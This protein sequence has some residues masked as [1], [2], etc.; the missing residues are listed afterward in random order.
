MRTAASR[1]GVEFIER[2]VTDPM[3][4]RLYFI[5][6]CA[7]GMFASLSCKKA[8][9]TETIRTQR[10]PYPPVNL[11]VTGTSLDAV[12][13]AWA[14]VRNDAQGYVV[15]RKDS[16]DWIELAS[17]DGITRSYHDSGL[18]CGATYFYTAYAFND[19]GRSSNADS[20]LATTK[21]ESYTL[22]TGQ[23]PN[24]LYGVAV[25]PT[26][27]LVAVG[28]GGT[29]L[30]SNDNGSSW[31]AISSNTAYN[32][33]AAAFSS[34]GDCII[35]GDHAT[36]LLL[37]QSQVSVALHSSITHQLLGL[38]VTPKGTIFIVGQQGIVLRSRDN[39][40]SWT[41]FTA[42][43]NGTLS[44]VAFTTELSGIV[45]TTDSHILGTDDGGLSWNEQL[46]PVF[47]S[48]TGVVFSDP[49]NG[50]AYG[51]NVILHTSNRGTAWV[52]TEGIASQVNG[53]CFLSNRKGIAV[54]SR[55]ILYQTADG[56]MSWTHITVQSQ[57]GLFAIHQE[58]N[59]SDCVAVGFRGIVLLASFC[60]P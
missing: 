32:L 26:G 4:M 48:L 31:N 57:P 30:Q 28:G 56:G 39:G 44:G 46:N 38:S 1:A 49:L 35:V 15:L 34:I 5:L 58:N 29:I 51:S 12:D 47:A 14:S 8:S 17:V 42:G 7:F 59:G 40:S 21:S 10:L 24:T 50:I 13:L 19:S 20:V 11:V 27:T 54:G 43:V 25:G 60:S 53:A 41:R 37:H 3:N 45:V 23:S 6:F 2:P 18:R 22:V 16:A 52:A 33:H 36:V 9:P 55:G